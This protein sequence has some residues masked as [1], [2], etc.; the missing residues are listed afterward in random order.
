LASG[1]ADDSGDTEDDGDEGNPGAHG[2]LFVAHEPDPCRE[3][4]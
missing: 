4:S 3:A 1:H 2:E